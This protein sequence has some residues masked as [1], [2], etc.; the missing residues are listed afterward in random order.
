MQFSKETPT[1]QFV[2]QDRAFS[3]PAPF[4]E[5]HVCTSAEA[6]VLNQTLAENVRNNL[7][8]RVKKAVDEDKFD[9][10]EMQA[11]IDQYLEDYEF[12]ARR[13]RGAMDPVER[14]ALNIAKDEVKTALRR[15]GHKLADIATEDINRLAEQV[16][17]ENPEIT[18][19]AERRVNQKSKIGIKQLDLSNLGAG[20]GE[21]DQAAAE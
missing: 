3:I 10:A 15:S 16:V 6:G 4:V 1:R 19:E 17:A 2:I 18:K 20:E 5:G 7:A 13:G 9:Q 8:A 12:G 21:E 11:E 14:E